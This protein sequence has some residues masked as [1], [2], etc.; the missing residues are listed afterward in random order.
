MNA[1]VFTHQLLSVAEY[2]NAVRLAASAHAEIHRIAS[3]TSR[4]DLFAKFAASYSFP[5]WASPNF[6]ALWDLLCDLSWRTPAPQVLIIGPL[7][8]LRANDPQAAEILAE[9]LSELP[10]NWTSSTTP[11]GVVELVAESLDK[12][13]EV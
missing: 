8:R 1:N 6:D 2:A 13:A 12:P 3:I 9:I 5:D 4:D 11:F 10:E 7:D